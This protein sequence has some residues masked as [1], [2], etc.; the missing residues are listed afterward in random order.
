[1]KR[2]NAWGLVLRLPVLVLTSGVR[3]GALDQSLGSRGGKAPSAGDGD[4]QG[5][6]GG[7]AAAGAGGGE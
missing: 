7:A 5:D 6:S 4:P 2:R 1:M 3:R